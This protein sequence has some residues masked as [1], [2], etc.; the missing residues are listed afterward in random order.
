MK[1]LKVLN[2][3]ILS[4]I[5]VAFTA[6]VPESE[7]SVPQRA[8]SIFSCD[9]NSDNHNDLII[10]HMPN[11]DA[12]NTSISLLKNNG[13]GL[14][15][16]TDTIQFCG[17]EQNIFANRINNDSFPDIVAEYAD[18]FG[19]SFIR[20]LYNDGNGNFPTHN[21]F[22]HTGTYFYTGITSGDFN[23]DQHQDIVVIVNYLGQKFWGIF[24]NDGQGNLLPPIYNNLS[25]FPQDIKVGD[26]NSDGNDDFVIAGD[27]TEMFFSTGSGFQT[28]LLNAPLAMMVQIGDMNQDG[29]ND[30]IGI[31]GFAGQTTIYMYDGSQNFSLIFQKQHLFGSYK[32]AISY[33]NNDSLPDLLIL[34]DS[35]DGIYVM[36]NTR[37]FTLDSIQFIPIANVGEN[38]RAIYCADLDGNGFN[39]I[40]I[41]RDVGGN[42]TSM[43]NLVILFNDGQGHFLP[44]PITYT[45]PGAKVSK[46]FLKIYPNPF[47]ERITFDININA[48]SY[49]TLSIFD[50][51]GH[52]TKC[53]PNDNFKVGNYLLTWNGKDNRNNNCLPG[54]YFVCLNIHGERVS[55]QK[56][57]KY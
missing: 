51:N 44:D 21:D 18:E 14:F 4:A 53:F 57:V 41:G 28:Q 43:A 45:Q 48:V 36:Y 22:F 9:I 20:I 17:Y 40:A 19:N 55:S 3:L 32:S 11:C 42:G 37:N 1:V 35:D 29:T 30:I 16:V 2:I 27:S 34:P 38:R 8:A 49:T 13:F 7:Y 56:I 26:L 10:G 31:N 24:Y 52:Q 23:E 25:F 33:L 12:L 15:S 46:S 39:D 54:I 5:L 6:S 47:N 50:I